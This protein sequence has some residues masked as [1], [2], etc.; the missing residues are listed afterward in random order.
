MKT[1]KRFVW[2]L[3]YLLPL[4]I[5]FGWTIVER[6]DQI[7][8]NITAI[9]PD[10]I[11]N[12]NKP[13][14]KESSLWLSTKGRFI[15][16][17]ADQ[18]IIL[19]GVNIASTSWGYRDWFPKAIEKAKKDWGA[20]VIRTRIYQEN[21]QKDKQTFYQNLEETILVPARENDLYVIL[22]PWINQNDSLPD[23]TTYKMWED[24]AQRYNDD[25]RIIY[26]VLAEPHDVPQEKVWQANQKLI[27]TIRSV[28]PKSLIMVTGIGWGRE[29]NSYYDNPLPYDNIV[30]RTNPYNKP[31]EFQAIFGKIVSEYPVFLGEFGADG[32]PPMS[33]EAVKYLLQLARELNLG[34]TA[35]NFHSVGCPCLLS[36]YEDYQPSAYGEIVKNSLSQKT[37]INI[38][39]SKTKDE[40]RTYIY[41]DYLE[42]GFHDLSWDAEVDFTH[43][44]NV[45][46]G[47]NSIK[48][49]VNQDYGALNL[50][51]Y[52]PIDLQNY[53]TLA[54]YI[55]GQGIKQYRLHLL[56]TNE[57]PITEISLTPYLSVNN[58]WFK[59][60][61]PLDKL[62]PQGKKVTGLTIKDS[63][64]APIAFYLDE[65]Y[66]E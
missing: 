44:E 36:S 7:I 13:A 20:N 64:Y 6:N 46:T 32:Y 9:F 59:V 4:V 51:A 63:G 26:D 23:E 3:I 5:L 37:V 34:W 25:P 1:R 66:F 49:T 8:Q 22:N 45:F 52:L 16:N 10:T 58:Q 19:R 57:Q 30:Y 17:A 29:I 61:I 2:G 65:V 28:H 40:N 43:T 55:K 11:T 54:F 47:K 31:G 24:I 56:D 39:Q 48:T 21:W 15:V 53:T 14:P 33:R 18:P 42:N 35:W 50:A 27:E 41:S 38:T 60:A 12:K 62:N